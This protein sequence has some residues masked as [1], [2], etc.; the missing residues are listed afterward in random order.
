[1]LPGG[2]RAFQTGNRRGLRS[3]ALGDL[4]LRKPGFMARLQQDIQERAFF[5]FDAFDFLAD[6]RTTHQLG[7]DL[8]MSSHA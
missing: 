7:N 5:T 2:Q 3:H 8:F 6:A 1:M 4:C